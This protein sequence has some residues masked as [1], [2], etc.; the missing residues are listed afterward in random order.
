MKEAGDEGWSKNSI[1]LGPVFGRRCGG[2]VG[3][4]VA[5]DPR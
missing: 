2:G 5:G 3:R 4:G 1:P